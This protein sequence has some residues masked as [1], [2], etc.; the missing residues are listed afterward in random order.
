MIVDFRLLVSSYYCFLSI[1]KQLKLSSL[2][3]ADPETQRDIYSVKN[4][5]EFHKRIWLHWKDYSFSGLMLNQR[6]LIL[7]MKI[8]HIIYL[9]L[10]IYQSIRRSM[11][12]S[13][14]LMTNLSDNKSKSLKKVFSSQ[15]GLKL[16]RLSNRS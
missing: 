5:L 3:P 12:I 14:N 9:I 1:T 10:A 15:K 16:L 7:K 6:H 13:R 8:S 2:L 11:I 4:S